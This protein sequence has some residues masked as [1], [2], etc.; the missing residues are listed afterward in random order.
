M[1]PRLSPRVSTR[2]PTEVNK[3]SCYYSELFMPSQN[4]IQQAHKIKFILDQLKQILFLFPSQ[5]SED[6]LGVGEVLKIQISAT[7][8]SDDMLQNKM[9]LLVNYSYQSCP[10]SFCQT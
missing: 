1:S 2:E 5:I 7:P 10:A 3:G 6:H 9:K 8:T 4:A